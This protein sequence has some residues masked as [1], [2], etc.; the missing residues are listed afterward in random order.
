MVFQERTYSV[1]L[2][3]AGG[4]FNQTVSGLLPPTHFGPV[5]IVKSSD[6]AR[7]TLVSTSYDMVL[8]NAPLPDDLGVQL[9]ISI[10][11]RSDAGVLLFVKNEVFQEVYDKVTEHG[12]LTLSKPTSTQLVLQSVRDPVSYTHLLS[13]GFF[14]E[15]MC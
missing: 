3:S 13:A 6:E 8:I 4:K 9:A 1:L 14:C 11:G 2:V 12:V 7:R 5:R 15:S 10:C